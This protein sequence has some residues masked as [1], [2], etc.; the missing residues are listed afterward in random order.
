[1]KHQMK[2]YIGGRDPETGGI[3]RCRTL[4]MREKLMRF[5][6]GEQLRVTVIVPGN[7][8]KTLEIKEVAEECDDE[9]N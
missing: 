9:S 1:M 3:V 8:V 5:L 6:F 4:P 7:S 2:I